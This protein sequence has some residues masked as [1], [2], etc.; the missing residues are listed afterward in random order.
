MFIP[1]TH[2]FYG[3]FFMCI[4]SVNT[5]LSLK[6]AILHIIIHS[7]NV[8]LPGNVKCQWKTTAGTAKSPEDFTGSTGAVE[9]AAGSR[10][11]TINI[12]IID[13]NIPEL[14]KTFR[15]ELFNPEGGGRHGC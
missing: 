5:F 7:L 9:F 2:H 10:N 1:I 3:A 8:F 14:S 6:E 4:P 11:S 13:D 12:T 15:V